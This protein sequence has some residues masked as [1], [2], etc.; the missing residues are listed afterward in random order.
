MLGPHRSYEELQRDFAWAIP[1][2]YNIGVD[3]CDK[4][5]KLDPDKTA[6]ICV[7]ENM[8]SAEWSFGA[9]RERSNQMANLLR[10][11]G[12]VPGD[13]VAILLPQ[14]PETAVAHIAVYKLGAIALPLFTLF[15]PESLL[16]R[17]R[18]SGARAI[19]A[20]GAGL[21]RIGR[22]A[23]ELPQLQLL[24]SVDGGHS[25]AVDL[26]RKLNGCSS[27]FEP[28]KTRADDPALIIYTSGTT[29]SPKGAVHAH[30]VLLGHLP[31]VEMSHDLFPQPGDRIWTP[32]DWAWIGGLVD[33]LLPA[34][35]HGVPVVARRFAKFSGEAAFVLMERFGVQ[36]AF[37]PPTALKMMRA[38]PDIEK[39]WKLRLRSVASGGESLGTEL[40]E[41]GRRALGVTI[42]EFYGQTECNMTVSSCAAVMA[43]EPGAMGRPVPGHAVD[44]IDGS[45]RP[46]E[47]GAIGTIAVRRPD[48]VM[49][50]G[51]WNNPAATEAKF[52][53]DWMLTGDSGAKMPG[54]WLRFVGRDDDLINS[55]GYRIGPVEIEDCLLKHPAV[56]MA[57]VVGKPD[58][59][60]T[61]IVKAFVVLKKGIEGSSA[62]AAEIGGYVKERLAAHEY[63]REVEFVAELPMTTTGKIIRRALREHTRV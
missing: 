20:S 12:I 41:W 47:I 9:L 45:G 6:L 58:P 34:L 24:L 50:V 46:C 63:P 23:S 42:N 11:R 4:W 14:V 32:A 17:L 18:D 3:V 22:I 26:Q 53:G 60:R 57:A 38:V 48:P 59:L 51:Y 56:A 21:E 16:H 37:I 62:L 35:H 44:V 39:R 2:Y 19:V 25:P 33:V 43:P 29:G 15:G 52:I 55:G 7:D 36:N 1:E 27:S 13:R 8:A 31:G 40:L 61:E 5:A 54:G 28:V 30:R 49:F 10:D